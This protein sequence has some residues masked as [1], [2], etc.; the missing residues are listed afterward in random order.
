MQLINVEPAKDITKIGCIMPIF[1][2]V[3]CYITALSLGHVKL[4]PLPM[5]SDCGCDTP[6]KWI[7]RLGL[8]TSAGFLTRQAGLVRDYLRRLGAGPKP[9][10]C[11]SVATTSVYVA[12]IASCGL[13][14]CAAVSEKENNPIHSTS[15]VI[16][17]VFYIGAFHLDYQI[18]DLRRFGVV[19]GVSLYHI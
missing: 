6:E 19:V 4:W 8:I 10:H 14:G 12:T 1:T 9:N 3:I 17:F 18:L 2:I 7:F 11:G 13:A 16:F 15:A 5:I